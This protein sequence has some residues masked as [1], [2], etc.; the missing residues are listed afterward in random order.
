MQFYLDKEISFSAAVS[1]III[2]SSFFAFF[3]YK[4]AYSFLIETNAAYSPL[5]VSEN[6]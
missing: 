1:A 2:I 3:I 6:R 4:S 5:G